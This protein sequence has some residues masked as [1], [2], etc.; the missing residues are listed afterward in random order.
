MSK[1]TE[2]SKVEH[3]IEFTISG[4]NVRSEIVRD[5][6]FDHPEGGKWK[7][8]VIKSSCA[9]ER[10]GVR[11]EQHS[12]S[13]R[14]NFDEF[15]RSFSATRY[16]A[17][18]RLV[19]HELGLEPDEPVRVL[20]V[21]LQGPTGKKLRPAAI[22]DLGIGPTRLAPEIIKAMELRFSGKYHVEAGSDGV[23]RAIALYSVKV[24]FDE[25]QSEVNV[26]PTEMNHACV[27]GG[28]F[29][30]NVLAD[31]PFLIHETVCRQY[32]RTLANIARCKKQYVL[33]LGKY[34]EHRIRLERIRGALSKFG[35]DGL[36]LDDLPDIEEQSLAE[37][38]V[39]FSSIARFVICDDLVP[40][41]HINELEIC[42]ERR[43]TTAILRLKGRPSTAM[44]TDIADGVSFMRA[45]EYECSDDLEDAVAEAV[46]WAQNVVRAR[47]YNFNRKYSWRSPQNILG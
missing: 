2:V 42:S 20:G 22:V 13:C 12:Y 41:G 36:I 25:Y 7:A 47:S 27:V 9:S 34:G 26:L 44:Q 43:F 33:I 28:E 14:E 40:S 4:V 46:K 3:V 30:Q 16:E 31:K 15:S 29:F 24:M 10:W 39:T 37:K 45:V 6:T 11:E 35:L 18:E 38:M 21:E 19:K 17:A 1:L 5:D 32:F 8:I 23:L